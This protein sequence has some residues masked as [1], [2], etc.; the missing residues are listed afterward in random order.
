MSKNDFTP[1]DQLIV[2]QVCV[3][4]AIEMIV[5]DKTDQPLA[6]AAAYIEK[7]VWDLAGSG[8]WATDTV[9]QAVP[10]PAPQVVPQSGPDAF[11]DAAR[12]AFGGAQVIAMPQGNVAA[13]PPHSGESRDKA[14]KA[15]NKAWGKARYAIAPDEFWD[16][17]PKKA[18]GEYKPT[19]P[20]LK[21]KDSALALWLD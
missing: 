9:L 17:R 20:D 3:K 4:G 19:S 7:V 21:H 13:M 1:K 5:A 12:E 18:A 6:A 15:A 14:E 16:N 11:A 10:T 2:A 8:G